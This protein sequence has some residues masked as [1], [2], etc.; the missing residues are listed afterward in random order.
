MLAESHR[1]EGV[2]RQ[3]PRSPPPPPPR[4][5]R[6]RPHRTPSRDA[7][8]SPTRRERTSLRRRR[9]RSP[10]PSSYDSYDSYDSY[11]DS[12]PSRS[13]PPRVRYY[14]S[15]SSFSRS[16]SPIPRRRHRRRTPSPPRRRPYRRRRYTRTPPPRRPRSSRRTR[17]PYRKRPRASAVPD[18]RGRDARTIFVWQLAKRVTAGDVHDLFS[19]AGDVRDVRLVTDRYSTRHKSAGYV[20]FYDERA[21]DRA[22]AMSGTNLCGFPV[23]VRRI[24]NPPASKRNDQSHLNDRPPR[25]RPERAH[26]PAA[27]GVPNNNSIGWSTRRP[28]RPVDANNN[29][30]PASSSA[31]AQKLVSIEE[32]KRLLN[33]NNLPVATNLVTRD[34]YNRALQHSTPTVAIAIDEYRRV[35]VGSIP[36]HLNE[37]ELSSIFEPYGHVQ[38]IQLQ[39]EPSGRS[40]GFAF[41]DFSTADAARKAMAVNGRMIAGKS[42]TVAFATTANRGGD[43]HIIAPAVDLNRKLVDR[44][45]LPLVDVPGEI[46]EGRE[47]GLPMN[48]AQRVMLMQE[49]SRGETMGAKLRGDLEK[50]NTSNEPSRC[51]VLSNMFDPAAEEAG[52]ERELLEE[53]RDE[54]MAKYGEVGHIHVETESHGIVY[55]RFGKVTE[56]CKAKNDLSG[57]WFGGKK[58]VAHF[59]DPAEYGK[60]FP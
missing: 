28:I 30:Q 46:D 36:Y 29:S 25:G 60:R 49:L 56:A 44:V 33:P 14:D 8:R 53:V 18:T 47:G 17:S 35:Q 24:T 21:V 40:R 9:R 20:E 4:S 7:S 32:L 12:S 15:E 26:E 19:D 57:R 3:S 45:P 50:L 11:S 34:S 48:T 1:S 43:G 31:S 42:L 27:M 37:A 59:V 6:P 52:F 23:A 54:C 13:P 41:V 38:S 22:V 16:R 55:L 58:I 39:R 10:T 2:R 5:D 51:L